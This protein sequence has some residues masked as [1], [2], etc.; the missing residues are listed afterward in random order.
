M[1]LRVILLE[2][3]A[4][5]DKDCFTQGPALSKS[6]RGP[7]I[8][9]GHFDAMYTYR[10]RVDGDRIFQAINEN[11]RAIAARNSGE[12]Y[13]HPLYVL[14]DQDRKDQEFWRGDTWC[15][16][17][18][19]IHY[20][21]SANIAPLH[22]ALKNHLLKDAEK[23]GCSCHIYHTMELSDLVVVVKSDRMSNILQFALR[24][25]KYS[26]V[27]KVYTYCGIDYKRVKETVLFPEDDDIIPTVSMRF[28][29]S[30]FQQV[31]EQ[32]EH[33]IRALN[34][35][36]HYSAVV[37]VDDILLNCKD[38]PLGKLVRLYRSRFIP[39]Y[40]AT[41]PLST[42]FPEVTTRLGITMEE[43]LEYVPVDDGSGYDSSRRLREACRQLVET[44]RRIQEIA[45]DKASGIR[46]DTVHSW[47]KPLS[48]LTK[49]LL[50]M[51]RTAVLDE[52]V[53]LMLP[54]VEAFLD[55]VRL[56]LEQ[57]LRRP[58]EEEIRL[59]D[60][61]AKYFQRFVENW[62]HLMEHV[63]RVEGQLAHH[64]ET[65]PMIYDIPIVMLE[66]TLAF[67]NMV[68]EVL[69][70][71]DLQKERIRFLL[72][73]YPCERINAVELFEA[74]KDVPGL[75]LVTIPFHRLY[76][77]VEVLSALAHETSHYV[78]E[79]HRKRAFRTVCFA[80]A[81]AV[82]LA[83]IVFQNYDRHLV[84]GIVEL[85]TAELGGC[86]VAREMEAAIYYWSF[87][88]FEQKRYSDFAA[89]VLREARGEA[90]NLSF[91]SDV[92]E[93]K[94]L[95]VPLFRDL[96]KDLCTLFR[97]I[98]A[99]T[100]MLYLLPLDTE[101]YISSL[102]AELSGGLEDAGAGVEMLAVRMFVALTSVGRPIPQRLTGA[103]QA[104]WRQ[105]HREIEKIRAGMTT[106][107]EGT[108]RLL[109]IASVRFLLE[110]ASACA[111]SLRT[112]LDGDGG[113][114]EVKE[115]F[116]AVS[117]ELEFDKLL[118]AISEY[119]KKVISK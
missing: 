11:N 57:R 103:D 72:V 36:E 110:Y 38:L 8:T 71:G 76:N 37:G 88:F 52:F 33:V 17:A 96:L 64:P 104:V 80:K 40:D 108:D 44:D 69:L 28:S 35:K 2:K 106:G 65:R 22:A 94:E 21:P 41:P 31:R 51:S 9:L 59:F 97:E 95:Y 102:A 46:Y 89:H 25:R 26:C 1:I 47:L 23:N 107:K 14:T 79:H 74:R 6:S 53:Y 119:R 55:Q 13:Y 54:G 78:G 98:Y 19:R 39:N 29:V 34:I 15:M 82:L 105:L 48:E 30:D 84:K 115:L 12:R 75:V 99:D 116:C 63:M 83:K 20:A 113:V 73:S 77:P 16:A 66:Y 118:E 68:S 62:S 85:F 49:S 87:E 61:R 4:S 58:N 117:G 42:T 109:P 27:G 101:A 10:L 50:R 70:V 43:D 111:E 67:L 92:V 91:T 24:L 18:A 93:L 3:I 5:M 114:K 7:W 45:L 81:A 112:S 90:E 56:H 86:T 32:M 100:C 60:N